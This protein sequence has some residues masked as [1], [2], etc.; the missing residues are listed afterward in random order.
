MQYANQISEIINAFSPAPSLVVKFFKEQGL[1]QDA[2]AYSF[3]NLQEWVSGLP[4]TR[5]FMIVNFHLAVQDEESLKRL[6]FSR[7][8]IEGMG[9][10]FI[11]LVTP[12]GDDRL[13]VGAYDF[14]SFVKLLILFHDDNRKDEAEETSLAETDEPVKE[15]VWESGD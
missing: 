6:N 10:N 1:I 5:T 14:Y 7:D 15:S 13:A 4:E 9:K 11:F 2:G 8:M 3:R 12:Y